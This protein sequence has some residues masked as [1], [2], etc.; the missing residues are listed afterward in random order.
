MEFNSNETNGPTCLLCER[1]QPGRQMRACLFRIFAA[2]GHQKLL[3]T[4]KNSA[5]IKFIWVKNIQNQHKYI[6]G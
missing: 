4:A 2:S 6:I 1:V 5:S 3:R